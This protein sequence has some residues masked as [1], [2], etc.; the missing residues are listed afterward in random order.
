MTTA[1]S[2]AKQAPRVIPIQVDTG[3]AYGQPPPSYKKELTEVGPGTPMGEL[4]R[5]YWHP[6]GLV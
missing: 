2:S 4:M 6:I 1:T 3:T 5:R